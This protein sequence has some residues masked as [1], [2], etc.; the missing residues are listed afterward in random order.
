MRGYESASDRVAANMFTRRAGINEQ[1]N[2]VPLRLMETVVGWN[3]P[4]QCFAELA[5]TTE[6]RCVV[7]G[8]FRPPIFHDAGDCQ[9][10]HFI[11]ASKAKLGS[12]F[13]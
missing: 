1:T 11:G 10:L 12:A 13:I 7:A 4:A 8:D 9:L 5:L 3:G 6:L 2:E